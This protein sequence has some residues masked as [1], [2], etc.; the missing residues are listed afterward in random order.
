MSYVWTIAA[1]ML[2]VATVLTMVR[3]LR[4]PTTLDRLVALDVL[5]I[6]IGRNCQLATNIQLL[7]PVH[8]LEPPMQGLLACW[9]RRSYQW[10]ALV[11]V[12]IEAP[13][14]AGSGPAP[15]KEEAVIMQRWV[16]A[17]DLRPVPADPNRAFGAR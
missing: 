6:R 12:I 4:G 17:A 15:A 10:E 16:P 8:P 5:D 2:L 7:T 9:R 3:I 13:T 14:A 1:A 11:I